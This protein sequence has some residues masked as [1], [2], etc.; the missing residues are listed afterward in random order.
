[1]TALVEQSVTRILRARATAAVT[2]VCLAAPALAQ[3]APASPPAANDPDQLQEVVVT[4]QFRSQRLQDTP[5]AITAVN[6]AMMEQRGQ[7][8][9]HDLADQAPNVTLLETGGAF[10]PG[11]TAS[12]RGIGQYDFDPAFSP[13][14]GIYIDDVYYTNLTG[15]NFDLLDLDRVE[16]LRGPQGT[17]AGAELRGRRH[18]ALYGQAGRRQDRTRFAPATGRAASS[19]CRRWAMSRWSR[20][21]CSCESPPSPISRTATSRG[22]TTAARIRLRHSRRGRRPRRTAR[23]GREGGKNYMGGRVALRWVAG[24][25]FEANLTGDVTVD[26]LG[27]RGH[28]VSG[29]ESERPGSVRRQHQLRR[30]AG[31]PGR[32]RST[33]PASFPMTLYQLCG[34]LRRGPRGKQ[35]LLVLRH[36]HP[37]MGTNLTMDW[38]LS[39]A[40]SLKSITGF[41][42]LDMSMDGG[43]RRLAALRLTRRRAA[44][45]SHPQRGAAPERQGQ[46]SLLDYTVGGYFLDQVTT[47]RHSPGPRLRHSGRRTSSSWATIR[48]GSRTT[49]PLPT[50][51]GTSPMH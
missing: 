18:Q 33:T 40:L 35:L 31:Q 16:I 22:W 9:L 39:D 28:H 51:P 17:L 10:G 14:V 15:S 42:E 4:A 26:E 3:T 45:Q 6:A 47:Y 36:L 25:N 1:M 20:V 2:C 46:G 48:C 49:R 27:D 19:T 50:P 7:T 37:L 11:M 21:R 24:D 13:G 41:R 5:I 32:R 43:Q 29:G 34:F 8:S 12:I 38:K 23:R 44:A 30:P